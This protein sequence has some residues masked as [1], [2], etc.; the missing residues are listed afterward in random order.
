[1]IQ[2]NVRRQL[3]RDDAQLALRL[4]GRDSQTDYDE[5]EAM[6]RDRG[7]D[8]VLDDPRLLRGLLECRAGTCAS[9]PLFC[10]VVVRHALRGVGEEDR[11][12]ADY[13]ASIL[14][15]FGLRH[16]ATRVG[17]SDDETYG[18]L[19]ELLG[20]ANDRDARRSF[21]VRAHLG[22]YALWISGLFPDYIA[23]RRWRRGAP[24]LDYYED[25]GRRGFELAAAHELAAANGLAPLFRAAAERFPAL[26]VA[27]NRVSDAYLFP[28]CHSPDRLLRQVRDESRWR[29]AS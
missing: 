4:V 2:P 14:L 25:L 21:L 13:V 20:A 1:M 29:L 11:A 16:R 27:L 12:L 7:L 19:A 23:T 26:R 28:D 24:D 10:Y 22:N 15:H 18:E 6:L 3:R 9:Y 5:A 17:E 8:T